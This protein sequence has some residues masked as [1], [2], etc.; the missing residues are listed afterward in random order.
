MYFYK[1]LIYLPQETGNR[2]EH[3][4]ILKLTMKLWKIMRFHVKNNKQLKLS[5]AASSR[6]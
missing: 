6:M 5:S 3:I 2:H 4:Y 1:E